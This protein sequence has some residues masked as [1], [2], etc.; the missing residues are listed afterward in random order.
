M[1]N[2][3]LLN[4]VV[5]GLGLRIQSLFHN[6]YKAVNL[7]WF[8]FKYYKHVQSNKIRTHRLFNQSLYF[9]S[10]PELLHA[11]QEIF[12]DNIYK[13]DLKPNPVIIDCGANI[14]MSV[15][16]LKRRFPQAEIIAF[17]PDEK[18]FELLAKNVASFG[19]S[20]VTIRKEA[21]WNENTTLLFSNDSSMSSKIQSENTITSKEVIATRLKDFLNRPVDFLKIDIEGAEYTVLKDIADDLPMVNNMFLEYHGDFNQNDE[22][23][24]IIGIIKAAGFNFYIKEATTVYATPFYRKAQRMASYDVQLNIFCFRMA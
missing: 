19:Y 9:F 13:Q 20:D 21:V 7:N 18:N 11:L 17:E 12:V 22:L 14:G 15:I 5:R 24:H 8:Y 16:Y 4:N 2:S 6:P 10:V 23:L 1:S 3:N